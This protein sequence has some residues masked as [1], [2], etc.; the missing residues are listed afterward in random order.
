V[1]AVIFPSPQRRKSVINTS[2]ELAEAVSNHK[3]AKTHAG[4]VL[5]LVTLT[6]DLLTSKYIGRNISVSGLVI[7][8][9][10]IFETSCGKNIQTAVKTI[11]P[12]LP[13]ARVT[14]RRYTLRFRVRFRP[15]A[16]AAPRYSGKESRNV[17][18]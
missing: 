3:S 1:N 5:S 10:S 13:S 17:V 12:Q 2:S 14:R 7:A 6:F 18:K 11:P 8:A 16:I 15:I 9:A 4:N